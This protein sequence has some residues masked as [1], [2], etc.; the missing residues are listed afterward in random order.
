MS[1]NNISQVEGID[2]YSTLNETTEKND[3]I[4]CREEFFKLIAEFSEDWVYWINPDNTI[5]YMSPSAKH[6]TGYEPDELAKYPNFLSHITY[7]KDL[8]K[9]K[10]HIRALKTGKNFCSEDFRIIKKNGEVRWISHMC[11]AVY[12]IDDKYIGR[13][14]RNVDISE[15]MNP[16]VYKLQRDKLV[17]N[18]C[19]WASVGYYQIYFD[20]RLKSAN[21]MFLDMIG[22]DMDELKNN[23]NF[24]NEFV[25]D[26]DKRKE[27]KSALQKYGFVKDF[28][29]TWIKRGWNI[30][31]LKETA[32]VCS[33]L[34][35]GNAYYEAFVYDVTERKNVEFHTIAATT[36]KQKYDELITGFFTNISHEIKTPLNVIIN[37]VSLLKSD[38]EA[39]ETK[40]INGDIHIIQT[41]CE[42]IKR[43]INLIL[44]M[45][46]LH[47]GTYDLSFSEFDIMKEIFEPL[48]LEYTDKIKEKNLLLTM[49]NNLSNAKIIGDRYGI[50]QIFLQLLDNA[51]KYTS[52][53]KIE[54]VLYNDE[55]NHIN[56]EIKDS[57]IG[58]E[59]EYIPFLFNVFSQ[60]DNGYSRMFQGTGLG[61]AIVK[62]HCELNDAFI[63]FESEKYKGTKVKVKFNR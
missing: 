10:N 48:I 23:P 33:N 1:S 62:K 15:K 9:S 51:L 58:I 57:G 39:N 60:E 42:K 14:V 41:E 35:G 11:Q 22:Y 8:S 45:S 25:F 28:E 13:Y 54:I 3:C 61:L 26:G 49:T 63:D 59:A 30:L 43:T 56:V 38:L 36:R 29:S 46:Q 47:S 20:G 2:L 34:S 27:F 31:Y 44:E 5:S 55:S 19:E 12:D 50:Y 18:I 4:A 21:K 53:G 32:K 24:E 40:S 7:A 52:T 6:I 16:T 37:M 17:K